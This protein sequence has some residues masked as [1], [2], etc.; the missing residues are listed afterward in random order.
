VIPDQIGVISLNTMYFFESNKAVGGCEY[1]E[2]ND[3]GNLQ[4]DWLEVQLK[5]FRAR[6]M[7]VGTENSAIK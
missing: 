6:H 1:K 3:A 4:F 2:P 7:L 5:S